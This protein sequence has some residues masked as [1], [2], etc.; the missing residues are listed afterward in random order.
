M[1]F[2]ARQLANNCYTD[3]TGDVVTIEAKT[4][5]GAKRKASKIFGDRVSFALF[6]NGCYI[7]YRCGESR[8]ACNQHYV[9]PEWVTF[10]TTV[11]EA[12]EWMEGRE[13]WDFE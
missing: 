4:I 3:W 13:P 9:A 6:L 5:I 2:K 11:E 1:E 8:N 7:G 12:V 10:H